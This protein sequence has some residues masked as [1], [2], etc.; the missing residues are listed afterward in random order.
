HRVAVDAGDD[1]VAGG[2]DSGAGGGADVDA[3]V[4]APVAQRLILDQHVPAEGGDGRAADRQRQ[5][6]IPRGLLLPGRSGRYGGLAGRGR[7]V[8][9][10]RAL[11]YP[12]RELVLLDRVGL[13]LL[14]QAL[15]SSGAVP[16]GGGRRG[17]AVLLHVQ[18]EEIVLGDV[19]R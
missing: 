6:E 19:L 4:G 1:T 10:Y 3:V 16:L 13:D 5:R 11:R 15:I 2:G 7:R 18:R 8:V 12:R 9:L 17:R 14:L